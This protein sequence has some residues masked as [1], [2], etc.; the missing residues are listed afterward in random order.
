PMKKA[1]ITVVVNGAPIVVALHPPSG[2]RK[3]WYAY[4][5]GLPSSKSTGRSDFAQAVL[6][7]EDMLR[8]GGEKR[9]LADT[10]LSDEEFVEIQ[11]RHY[12]KKKGEHAERRAAKSLTSCLEA[13]SA[14]R[15]ISELKPI[16]AARP[17]DCERFQQKALG[18]LA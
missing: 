6:A 3:S 14:F 10:V 16:T 13:I 15:E 9:K 17:E 4:W 18:L 12:G 7:V 8:N 1:R 11:R 2:T 5:A